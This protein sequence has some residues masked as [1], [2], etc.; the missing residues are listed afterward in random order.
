MLVFVFR[1]LGRLPLVWVHR[2]GALAGW[3]A[4]LG[5]ARHRHTLRENL[6]RAVGEVR[7]RELRRAAIAACGQQILELAW[8]W[9]RP[10]DEVLAKIV[11]VEGAQ[12]IRDAQAAGRSLLVLTPHLGCFELCSIWFGTHMG[13]CTVLYRPPRQRALEPILLAGRERG[14]VRMAPANAHGVRMLVR[15]LR[16]GGTVGILPDQTPKSGD[17]I[18]ATFFGKPAWTMTLAARLS[19]MRNVDVLMMRA[20][21]LPRGAGY[22]LH[23]RPP[24]PPVAGELAARAQ[25]LN[26]AI[27]HEILACPAQYLW[28]YPRYK[29]PGEAA[30]LP[31]E[32][33]APAA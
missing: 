18:W 7:A 12:H 23:I 15:T 26:H 14:Q 19:E 2:L 9:Q 33:S 6:A 16:E 24:A 29:V 22:V 32:F 20:E 5:S 30:P 17:G 4:Y 31:P 8:V 21:R 3:L 10:L 25:A 27:E 28:A 1:L 13:S 11:R